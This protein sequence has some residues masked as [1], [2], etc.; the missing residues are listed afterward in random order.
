[1]SSK[2]MVLWGALPLGLL[3]FLIAIVSGM[4][5]PK[6]D[7]TPAA[8]PLSNRSAEKETAPTAETASSPA[9]Q[10]VPTPSPAPHQRTGTPT[11]TAPQLNSKGWEKYRSGNLDEAE[12]LFRHATVL[13]PLF[14]DPYLNLARVMNDREDFDGAYLMLKKFRT[15]AP[16][17]PDIGAVDDVITQYETKKGLRSPG[18]Q[19][20]GSPAEE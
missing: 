6:G 14:P 13:D 18:T 12:G 8:P 5:G 9:D 17:H 2:R 16:H 3:A 4:V 11:F 1:M 10:V 15:L 7:S 19:D 20:L